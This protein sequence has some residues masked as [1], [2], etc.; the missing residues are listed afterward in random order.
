MLKLKPRLDLQE[1]R[2]KL[3]RRYRCTICNKPFVG[4]HA[5]RQCSDPCRAEAVRSRGRVSSQKIRD[6]RRETLPELPCLWCRKPMQRT[7][8]TRQTCSD[9]CRRNE[10]RGVLK[11]PHPEISASARANRALHLL[12]S[13]AIAK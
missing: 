2:Q 1:H 5:T 4:H 9:A 6:A 10:K 12:I 11:K 7:R 8:P 3:L 13:T